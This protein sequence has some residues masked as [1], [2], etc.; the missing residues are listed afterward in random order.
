MFI[1]FVSL[2]TLG[3]VFVCSLLSVAFTNLIAL[4]LSLTLTS[5]LQL[6]LITFI[7]YNL[8]S[9]ANEGHG[10]MS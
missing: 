2:V 8:T 1:H 4:T 5:L 9:R 6:L 7:S 3:S 10:N